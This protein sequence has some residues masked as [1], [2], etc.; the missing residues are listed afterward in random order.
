MLIKYYSGTS[1]E[2]EMLGNV[3]RSFYGDDS[4]VRD[5]LCMFAMNPLL[6]YGGVINR[7]QTMVYQFLTTPLPDSQGHNFTFD[8]CCLRR[9]EEI[10][11]QCQDRPVIVF[12]SGGIDSTAMLT[13]LI[14][15]ND[16]W[17]KK[18]IIY[19][20]H[21]AVQHEYPWFWDRYL[22]S[23]PVR[24][25]ANQD[26][27]QAEIYQQDA[28][29]LTGHCAD[30]LWGNAVLKQVQWDGMNHWHRFLQD[31]WFV[32]KIPTHLKTSVIE[33]IEQQVNQFPRS[34]DT[35]ID[36]IWML[37]FTH[38]WDYA[39][40]LQMSRVP[41]I[42]LLNRMTHFYNTEDFQI[43]SMNNPQARV[44]REYR[45]HKQVAKDFIYR[46]TKDNHYRIHKCKEMSMLYCCDQESL[47]P[48]WRLITDH[49]ARSRLDPADHI[50]SHLSQFTTNQTEPR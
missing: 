3:L 38:G 18:L 34:I 28:L 8:D 44:W 17:Q 33:F 22:R 26:F 20:S 35:V 32:Q 47:R 21:Y 2:H 40:L 46:L 36:L 6:G 39:R 19:T 11:R 13:A 48:Y 12:W 4:K 24:F 16:D 30:L 5:L 14:A 23:L 10:W 29:I 41:V 27:N 15:T 45:N 50:A 9:A 49:G 7:Q 31:P 37:V 1:V 43:W 42:D 25:L